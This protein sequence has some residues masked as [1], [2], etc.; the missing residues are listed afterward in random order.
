MSEWQTVQKSAYLS[1][2]V[3]LITNTSRIGPFLG[4]VN[5]IVS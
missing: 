3:E 2:F 4:V 1:D 5:M